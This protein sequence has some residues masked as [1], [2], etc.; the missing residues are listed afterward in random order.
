M[1]RYSWQSER[2]EEL[3]QKEIMGNK[4]EKRKNENNEGRKVD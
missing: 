2:H 1:L 4:R 3:K